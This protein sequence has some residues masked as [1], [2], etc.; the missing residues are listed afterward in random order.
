MALIALAFILAMPSR[1]R[2]GGGGEKEEG[3]ERVKPEGGREQ[4]GHGFLAQP[5]RKLLTHP[6][7]G[8]IRGLW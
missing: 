2:A 6:S 8:T 1:Q 7:W 5:A 3:W 4:P